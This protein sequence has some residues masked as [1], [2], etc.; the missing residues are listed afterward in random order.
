MFFKEA[1]AVIKD[2]VSEFNE[3]KVLRLSAAMA[4]YAIFSIGPLLVLTVG[5]T[6]L[7]FGEDRV[8][9]EIGLQLQ[10]FVGKDSARL[11]ESLM[12]SRQANASL[13]ATVVGGIALIF[14][15]MGVFGQL[16]DSLNTIWEVKAKPGA[17]I[18]GFIRERILSMAMVLGIGFLLLVSMAL[19]TFVSA[20]AQY[21]GALAALPGWTA[22]AF[23]SLVSLLVVTLLFATIFKVL[24][25]AKIRWRDVWVGAV[26]TAALF[27]AGKFLLGFYLGR[28]S[29]ASAYGAG[30]AFV[31]V[32]MYIYYS[33]LILFV[34]AEFTQVLARRRG[35]VQPS[36]YAVPVTENERTE[37]GM[38]RQKPVL[39]QPS[40]GHGAA[41][42]FK[43]GALGAEMTMT[44]SAIPPA[45]R[46][47]HSSPGARIPMPPWPLLGMA[48][49][50]GVATGLLLKFKTLK[51]AA[52]LYSLIRRI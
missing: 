44:Q 22:Q 36:K 47:G 25:D 3:D 7:A 24:P 21:I 40:Q 6:G 49:A 51:K 18:W 28:Q 9:Q 41:P 15:A 29:S 4:Y 48:L 38:P 52:E 45:A 35:A 46:V 13:I 50:M 17:G 37:E 8:R 16:Q 31:L 14:G 32:L 27:T 2:T 33:S 23:N 1:W 11:V 10:G 26:G 34:G 12:T 39:D 43:V 20:F 19:E 30:S 42:Q 5:V